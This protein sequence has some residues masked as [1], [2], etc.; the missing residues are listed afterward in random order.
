MKRALKWIGLVLGCIVLLL[1]L[2][3]VTLYQLGGSAMHAD[4][5]LPAE[6]LDASPDSAKFARGAHI[7]NTHGCT[8]CH[9]SNLGGKVF[10]DAPPFFVVASNLTSGEGGIGSTY[11]D[12]SWERALRHGVRPNGD[13]LLI[14]PSAAYTFLSDDDLGAVIAYLRTVPPVDN[15]LPTTHLNPLGRVLAGAGA[16]K[17]EYDMIDHTRPHRAVAPP[18][19]PTAEYGEYKAALCGYCHGADL[20]GAPA[21]D[22]AAPPGPDLFAVKAWTQDQFFQAMRTGVAPGG[23]TLDPMFMPWTEFAKLTDVELQALYA[24]LQTL[25]PAAE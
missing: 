18:V 10:V 14:M 25:T 13:G 3:G 6:T 11:T 12:E 9:E 20:R 16:L 2:V 8:D 7:V 4:P 15:E 19:A 1:L 23:R 5:S 24:Y 22:P 21:M 17:S